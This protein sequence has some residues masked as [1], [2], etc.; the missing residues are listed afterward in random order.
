MYYFFSTYSFNLL[1]ISTATESS[2]IPNADSQCASDELDSYIFWI[3]GSLAVR[4]F[5]YSFA[6]TNQSLDFHLKTIG[7]IVLYKNFIQVV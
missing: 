3:M 5:K 1:P 7:T 6:F 2:K 4:T